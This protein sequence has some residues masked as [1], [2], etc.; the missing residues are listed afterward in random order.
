M[1]HQKMLA[2]RLNNWGETPR[3]DE[4]DVPRPGPGQVLVKVAGV[5]LCGSD[6]KMSSIPQTVGQMLNWRV[7]FTLGHEVGGWIEEPGEGVEDLAPGEP[8]ALVSS[9]S[10]GCCSFCLEGADLNCQEG[11]VGRGYGRDGGLAPYVLVESAREIIKLDSLNPATAGPLTDAGA[12]AYHGVKRVLPKLKAGSTAVVIGAG[13]LGSF[14][15][16]LLKVLSQASVVA[17]DTNPARLDYVRT[18]G[19]DQIINSASEEGASELKQLTAADPASA[20]L[21][22]V[23]VDETIRTGLECLRRGGSYGLVG[24]SGG[25]L[26]APWYHLLPKDGEVFTYEGSSIS[27]TREVIALAEAGKIRNE[28]DLYPFGKVETAYARLVAGKLRG[29]A[30]VTFPV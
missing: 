9:H 24:A 2:F 6:P 5:G 14:A 10:C 17:L 7:P 30:V 12:T 29:R 16:Q 11:H 28:V 3:V 1:R 4:V 19:A 20:V 15:V 21:D 25:T 13:G 22:F 23:G 8:V 18:L 27:D 26:K